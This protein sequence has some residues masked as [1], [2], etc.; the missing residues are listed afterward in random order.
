M[1]KFI[2]SHHG[3]REVTE[4]E[5]PAL[6]RAVHEL[7]E[8]TGVA[9]PSIH[10]QNPALKDPALKTPLS[11]AF[12]YTIAVS[13]RA[14]GSTLWMGDEALRIFGNRSLSAP[15]GEELTAVLAHEFGHLQKHHLQIK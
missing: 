15:V 4:S 3:F 9:M 12:D 7:S 14:H 11:K 6:F 1:P 8:K 10:V 2:P 5:A 13:R